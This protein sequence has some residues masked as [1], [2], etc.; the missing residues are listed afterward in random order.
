VTSDGDDPLTDPQWDEITKRLSL[1]DAARAEI[2]AAIHMARS[3]L[4]T[5][6]NPPS[7]VEKRLETVAHAA[8][9][10][11]KLL[12]GLDQQ[13]RF[14][15]IEGSSGREFGRIGSWIPYIKGIAQ[16]CEDASTQVSPIG[17]TWMVDSLIASLDGTLQKFAR[18]RVCQE[19]RV[20][21]FLT[22]VCGIADKEFGASTVLSAIKRLKPRGEFR[23]KKLSKSTADS[24]R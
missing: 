3:H 12:E 19:K 4:K 6:K 17:R 15:L 2:D 11:A 18:T 7:E 5:W 10:L 13:E 21:S 8:S 24:S 1:P 16:A 14:E 9:K 22:A 23:D 20:I